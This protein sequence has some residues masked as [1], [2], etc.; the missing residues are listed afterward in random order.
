MFR[1]YLLVIG[2]TFLSSFAAFFLKKA[3]I[4]ERKGNQILFLKPFF[5]LGVALYFIASIGSIIALKYLSYSTVYFMSA[6][7]YIWSMLLGITLL[8]ENLNAM[9][10]ISILLIITGIFLII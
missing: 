3:S 7:T 4:K 6:F 5:Y 8:K 10:T 1:Y 9:K 2:Y